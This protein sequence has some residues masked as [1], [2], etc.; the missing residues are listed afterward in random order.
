MLWLGQILAASPAHAADAEKHLRRALELNGGVPETWVALIQF[1]AVRGNVKEADDLLRQAAAKL[2]PDKRPLALAPCYELLGRLDLARE[3]YAAALQAR[4]DDVG[5]LRAVAGFYLRSHQPSDAEPFLRH[6]I[7]RKV[8]ASADDVAWARLGLAME[9]ASRG[10]DPNFIQALALVGLTRDGGRIVEVPQA[11]EDTVE[12]RRARAHVL[13]TRSS[14]TL[15]NKAIEVLEELDGQQGL[16]PGDRFLLAQLYEIT[17]AWPKAEEQLRRLVETAGRQPAYLA[18][19]IRNLF[20]QDKSED[21]R[22]VIARLEALEKERQV[23]PGTFGTVELR[24]RLLEATGQ[25]A[26]AVALLSAHAAREGAPADEVLLP[27]NSLIRQK[28]YEQALTLMEQAWQTKCPPDVLAEAHVTLLRSANVTGGGG[29]SRAERLMR[30]ALVANPGSAGLL[31][32]LAGLEDLRGRF[33]E[34]EGYYRQVIATDGNNA[35]ALNNLAWLLAL[36]EQKGDEALPMIQRAIDLFGPRPDLLDTRAL[37]YLALGQPDKARVD[38]KAAIADTPTATRYLHL[39]RVCRTAD[40]TEGAA[41]ALREAKALGLKR[42]QL[43]PVELAAC[44]NLL[45][46]VD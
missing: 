27:I 45:E 33:A 40:D 4:R 21:A 36:R 8:K 28:R 18:H 29:S 5:V 20:R 7:D 31:F 12:R 6:I 43:H 39:A 34:A 22:P 11:G 2:A 37:V 24:A 19:L 16:Y 38:L 44:T 32:G 42:A 1:L 46:G 10:D 9:L 14:R 26:Q 3:Q 15:H 17:G 30:E 35:R 13:A 25:G 23:A 41:A